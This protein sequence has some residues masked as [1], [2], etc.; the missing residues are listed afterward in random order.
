MKSVNLQVDP[1]TGELI[2]QNVMIS[3][4]KAPAITID[5]REV[6]TYHKEPAKLVEIIASQ[7]AFA[8]FDVSTKA[9]R[10]ACKSHAANIIRCI[11]PA[12]NESKRMAAD[13]KKIVNQDI[14]FRRDFEAGIRDLAAYHRKPLTEWEEEQARIK[15][16][17]ELALFKIEEA[18]QYLVDWQ[19]AIDFNEL[20]ELR[21]E[22]QIEDNKKAEIE[23]KRL[24]DEEVTRKAQEL[25]TTPKNIVNIQDTVSTQETRPKLTLQDVIVI[26]SSACKVDYDTAKKML[27]DV[28]LNEELK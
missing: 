15:E 26:I 28:L 27:I 8:T 3:D 21:R 7:A 1:E 20:F 6:T 12:I 22:K 18:K 24:F 2:P 23:K 17:E 10:E 14:A 16:A 25:V 9:G 11:S 19:D 4:I 5:V 13:A